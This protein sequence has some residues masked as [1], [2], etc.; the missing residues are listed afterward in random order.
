[1]RKFYYVILYIF[2]SVSKYYIL[3]RYYQIPR[4]DIDLH[5]SYL[6]THCV[7]EG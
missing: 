2:L 6:K 1:M 3:C 5:S 4:G 7:Y